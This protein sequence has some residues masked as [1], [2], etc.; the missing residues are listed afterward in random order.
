LSVHGDR[1]RGITLDQ[2]FRFGQCPLHRAGITAHRVRT[3]QQ[4]QGRRQQQAEPKT[5]GDTDRRLGM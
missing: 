2:R 5:P 3:G 1:L 4:D